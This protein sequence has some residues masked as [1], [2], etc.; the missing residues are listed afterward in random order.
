[1]DSRLTAIDPAQAQGKAKELLDAVKAKLGMVPNMMRTMA[2]SPAAWEGYWAFSGALAKGALP[3]KCREQI[4]LAVAEMNECG[5]CAAA[6]TAL[7][8][9]AGLTPEQ[10]LAAR[11]G[12]GIDAK[13]DAGLALARSVIE[14]KG[15]VSDEELAVARSSGLNDAEIAEVVAHVALNVFTNYFNRLAATKI[16]FPQIEPIGAAHR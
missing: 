15:D 5:Y 10:T 13:A 2:H 3:A 1:M 12:R 16:D 8:K 11:Q 4:A 9:M 7:G 6:H 14:N